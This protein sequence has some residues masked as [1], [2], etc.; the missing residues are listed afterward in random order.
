MPQTSP[1]CNRIGVL[2]QCIYCQSLGVIKSGKTS[3]GKQRFLCRGCNRKFIA[4]YTYAAYDSSTNTNIV[5]L[6]KEGVGIRSTARLLKISAKIVLAILL[7][8]AKYI[9]LPPIVKDKTYEV[10]ELRTLVKRKDKLI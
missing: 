5:K 8:I 2:K 1:S 7:Q 4:S 10:G 3:N 9:E 6:L